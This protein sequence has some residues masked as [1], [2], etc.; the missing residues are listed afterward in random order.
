MG[1]RFITSVLIADQSMSC[2][3]DLPIM[4]RFN[5]AEVYNLGDT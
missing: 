1:P 5:G 2:L 4:P 3:T